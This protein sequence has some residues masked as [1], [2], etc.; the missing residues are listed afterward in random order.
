MIAVE[1]QYPEASA[2]AC[3][4][5]VSRLTLTAFRSY[6]E[7]RIETDAR[8]VALLGPN[9]AGKTNLLEAVSFLVPGRGLRGARLSEVARHV[10]GETADTAAWAVAAH[11]DT[12]L[13]RVEIGTGRDPGGDSES[14]RRVVRIDGVPARSQA[15]LANH[16]AAVWL[17]PQMDRLFTESASGRRRFLDRLVFGFDQGHAGRVAGYENAM[18]QR[19][20]LLREGR[21]DVAWLAALEEAMATRAVAVAAARCDLV[22]RLNIAASEAPGPFPQARTG[23][24]GDVEDWLG[25]MPA[26]AAED[27][28]REM[29]AASRG[30]DAEVGGAGVGT[31]RSDMVVHEVAR[32]MPAARCST[33]EQKALLVSIVLAHARLVA[34]AHGAPPLLLLDEVAAHLDASR[35]EALFDA[36]CAVGAQAWMTGTDLEPF[37]ALGDRAQ[38]LSVQN[39]TVGPI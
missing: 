10:P 31:H 38:F 2:R 22:R 27:R 7:A 17:T 14:E 8:P 29:L 9:G 16:A 15:A 24:A 12:P 39:S 36:V 1:R 19:A 32:D 3:P 37:R 13:G 5:A 33:G 23:I 25:Q 20:R 34:D 4:L 35:R 21:R 18:R 28:L 26:L 6:R 30:R 11:L